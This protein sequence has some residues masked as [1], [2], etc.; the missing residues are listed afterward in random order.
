MTYNYQI[1]NIHK[2]HTCTYTCLFI[3]YMSTCMD[4]EIFARMV[5]GPSPTDRKTPLQ[6][7]SPQLILQW[8]LNGYFKGTIIFEESRRGGGVT[9]FRGSNLFQG[10]GAKL[11]FSIETCRTRC[12]P[13][14]SRLPV[15][16]PSGFAHCP[17]ARVHVCGI[18]KSRKPEACSKFFKGIDVHGHLKYDYAKIIFL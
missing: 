14:G 16:P 6:H 4:P 7:F 3:C 17:C 9:N 10:D 11:H 2:Q 12:S 8:E 1:Q 13:G 5:G 15:P 18:L